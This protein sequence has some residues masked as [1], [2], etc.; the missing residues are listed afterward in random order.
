[1]TIMDT[2]QRI[3]DRLQELAGEIGKFAEREGIQATRI[4]ALSLVRNT[5]VTAPLHM[6]YEP[7]IC[8]V[9]QGRKQV[10]LGQESYEYGPAD[11]FLVSV[12]LPI[13]GQVIEALP[14]RPYLAARLNIDPAQ[15]LDLVQ[16]S[17][18]Q[19]AAAPARRALCVSRTDL[20]LTD[21]MLRLVRLLETPDYIDA[22]APLVIREILYRL[23]QDEQ[24]DVLRQLA[25]TGSSTARIAG[26][27]KR[28]KEQ[29]EQPLRIEEL[30]SAVN[31]SSS[32]LHRY[33]K[34][35]TGMSPLQYQKQVR[36]QEARRMLL[37]EAA[38]AAE[39]GY[40][41]G[42]E[43]PSQFSREYARLFG[44]PPMSDIK[45]L[46]MLPDEQSG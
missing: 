31:M 11:Y 12:D 36:L 10:M 22:L 24:G 8:L 6:I 1:M 27:V 28:I 15:I 33:F 7:A 17:E 34:E 13:S 20:G 42:Y 2:G 32:S 29:Y 16:E 35:V 25:V 3:R 38:D 44:L 5:E 45:R 4:P 41:V 19:P 46:R 40:R 21:A 43:S 37:S 18:L 30:A 14:D 26:V 39:V 23:L 9:A